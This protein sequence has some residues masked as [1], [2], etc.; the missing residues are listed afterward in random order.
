[1]PDKVLGQAEGTLD[2]PKSTTLLPSGH[3]F[4]YFMQDVSA[5]NIYG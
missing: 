3:V 5:I 2:I 4:A 1:M